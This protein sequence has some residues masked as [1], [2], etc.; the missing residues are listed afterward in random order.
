[1]RGQG[2]GRARRTFDRLG[3]LLSE[4]LLEHG[5]GDCTRPKDPRSPTRQIHDRRFD[6][7]R[8]GTGVEDH[9]DVL[10]KIIQDMLRGR[11]TDSAEAIGTRCGH[12]GAGQLDQFAGDP[13][14]R[15]AHG[16]GAGS[17]Q[18]GGIGTV[19]SGKDQRQGARPECSGEQISSRG[20]VANPTDLNGFQISQMDNRGMIQWASL[21]GVEARER[22]GVRRVRCESVDGLRRYGNEPAG[23]EGGRR[24]LHIAGDH[25]M[26]RR[27]PESDGVSLYSSQ[28][29]FLLSLI[30][31]ALAVTSA[32]G[33][34]ASAM[35]VRNVLDPNGFATTVVSV[36]QSPA[37]V[38]R[39]QARVEQEIRTLATGQP[40]IIVLG[41]SVLAGT[42][43]ADAIRSPA[44]ARVLGPA[45]V[46]LQQGILTGAQDGTVQIDVRALATVVKPP[47][48]VAAVLAVVPGDLMLKAP[49]LRLSAEFETALQQLDRHRQL[50]AA[51]AGLA[52]VLG[53]LTVAVARRR[54]IAL[55]LL[56]VML[57]IAAFFLRS[58]A[59]QYIARFVVGPRGDAERQALDQEVID[60]VLRGW[61]S[62]SG[63]L[64]GIGLALALVG[65]TFSLRRRR[66]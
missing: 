57:V 23:A 41:V 5:G 55:L 19:A 25:T 47:P 54:G 17:T 48:A 26:Y 53:L 30:L 35:L 13:G 51:L 66:S 11:W 18:R 28:V 16:N 44:A 45:A 36:L 37:G 9:I 58:M 61:G 39:V 7:D 15:N 24:H 10:T 4:G 20:P 38:A 3:E 59:A 31:A 52:V 63:A 33:S 62:V 60:Q 27:M 1:M 46:G 12:A 14:V 34:G 22:V 56:G 42:W 2:P 64:I 6:T 8:T 43:A 32:L 29:R 21:D 40:E 49:W 50:P 65:L